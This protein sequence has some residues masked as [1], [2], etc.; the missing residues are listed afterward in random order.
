VQQFFYDSQIRRFIIQFGRAIS[1]FQVEIGRDDT[2]QPV[3]ATIPTRY[4]DASKQAATIIQENSANSLPCAPMMT[5]YIN[6][7]TY[8]RA[9]VQEPYFVDRKYI[10]QRTWNDTTQSYENTQGN[11]FTVERH[12]PAPW[13]LGITLDIWTTNT[14]QKWQI[15]EQLS[16]LFNPSLE[17]QSTDNYL[18]WTSLSAIELKDYN[19]SSRTVGQGDGT[20][21]DIMSYRFELPI[22]ITMPAR[23][24][25]E[26]VI[27][28]I[29]A[30]I[31]DENGAYV[32]AIMDDD[33]LLGTRV[34]ITPH[35]YQLLLLGNQLQV[36]RQSNPSTVYNQSLEPIDLQ[37]SNISWHAVIDEYGTLRNGISYIRLE[38]ENGNEVIGTVSYHPTDSNILIFNVNVD[39]IPSNTLPPVDAVINPQRSGPGAGLQPAAVG[40]RYLL[41]DNIGDDTDSELAT[42]W[43]GISNTELVANTNDIIE[44]NGTEWFVAFDSDGAEQHEYVTNIT[45]GLQYK[46]N[47]TEWVRSYEGIYTGGQWGIVL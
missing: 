37:D 14:N 39:T 27:H 2:G 33:I 38:Q 31:Y 7:L 30:S 22:W 13:M 5:Y 45:S 12:M 4:G 17:L 28:K 9:D 46:W 8:R 36:L 42:A 26:G 24:S 6:S 11:A 23:V 3:Y 19:Y 29:I 21:I 15:F 10:R 34:K 25:K 43:S 41:T 44:Y 18:D 35:G 40:Q 47:G 16:P 20:E 1:G 32:D